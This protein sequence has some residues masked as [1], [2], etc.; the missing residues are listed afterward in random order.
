MDKRKT[1]KYE[2]KTWHLNTEDLALGTEPFQGIS[3]REDY[4]LKNYSS[5]STHKKPPKVFFG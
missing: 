3:H 2:K 1:N 5:S 4:A